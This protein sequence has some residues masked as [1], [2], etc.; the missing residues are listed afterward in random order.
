MPWSYTT[1]ESET[2]TLDA[3]RIEAFEVQAIAAPAPRLLVTYDTG[4]I[5]PETGA[6]APVGEVQVVEIASSTVLA[7]MGAPTLDGETLH[8]AVK[9]ILYEALSVDGVSPPG[10]T[11]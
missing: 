9:R 1:P 10:S 7:S 5:D 6:F 11:T 2:T 4:A 3:L 8:D